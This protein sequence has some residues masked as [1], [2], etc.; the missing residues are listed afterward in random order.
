ML[1]KKNAVILSLIGITILIMAASPERASSGA[2][3]SHTGAPNEQTCATSGC[4]DDNSLN[5]GAAALSIEMGNAT[6]QYIAGQTYPIKI[7]ITDPN[8]IRFGFQLVALQNQDLSNAGIFE[9][10]DFQRT[11]T[12]PSAYGLL[13][14]NYVTYTFNGTDATVNGVGEWIVNWKAPNT[15]TGLIT[16]YAAAVSANDDMTDKGDYVYTSSLTVNN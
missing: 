9:I 16:F 15:S 14:R 1:M 7:K 3:A 6:T 5:I 13:D 10:T 11:Q 2:P 12:V 4:H 8:K